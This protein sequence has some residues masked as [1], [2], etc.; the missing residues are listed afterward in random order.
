MKTLGDDIF[1]PK[2]LDRARGC[3]LGQFIGDAFGSQVE[4]M[5]ANMIK[6]KYPFGLTKMAN[7]GRH[8]SLAGQATDDSE[9]CLCL[10]DACL[11]SKTYNPIQTLQNYVHWLNTGPTDIGTT[12][13][14][15]LE[16]A[17]EILIKHDNRKDVMSFIKN[18]PESPSQANGALMRISPLAIF[19]SNY[20]TDTLVKWAI[21]DA[22]LT[23]VNKVCYDANAVYVIAL[24]AA[25]NTG[26]P[27]LAYNKSVKWAIDNKCSKS[28]LDTI[29]KA[30][31][32][33][34]NE[35]YKQ[36][37]WVLIALQNAFHYLCNPVSFEEV[38][39]K[40]SQVGGDTDTNAC[41]AGALIGAVQGASTFPTE[42]IYTVLNCKPDRSNP[43]CK[44]PRPKEFWANNL[45]DMVD[46][47]LAIGYIAS[48]NK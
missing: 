7:G 48:Q 41:I 8:N 47:L 19:G 10:I 15:A 46:K 33:L 24:Q 11:K 4:F 30:E 20:D 39:I 14:G 28:I 26:D 16:E 34:P 37:G 43:I 1:D 21:E 27:Q 45:L 12:T 18:K 17:R 40:T 3:L 36:M 22:H 35:Y 44:K 2:I 31:T 13:L 5:T 9:M 23:H 32:D 38:I 6:Q 42:W 29:I 25:I